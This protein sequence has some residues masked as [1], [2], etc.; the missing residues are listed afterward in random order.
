MAVSDRAVFV[1]KDGTLVHDVPYNADPD[2]IALMPSAGEGLRLLRAAAYR[3]VVV[4]NQSGVARGFFDMTA[5]EDVERRV[6][7]LL[8]SEGVVIDAFAVCPHHPDGVVELYRLECDCRKPKPGLLTR[9]ADDLGIDL[10]RSW[11]V[12]DILDDVEAGRRAGCRSVLLDNGHENEW[13]VT[14]DRTPDE[15]AADLLEA[16]RVIRAGDS[17]RAGD[18]VP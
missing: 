6:R 13:V 17:V 3:I 4:S 14:L 15:R 5:V 11:M 8:A 7:E 9:V 16:A 10:E 18:A 1:D 12:G 2:R